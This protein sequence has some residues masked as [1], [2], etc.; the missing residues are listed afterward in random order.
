MKFCVVQAEDDICENA[1]S[2]LL[3]GRCM[4]CFVRAN[5]VSVNF[6]TYFTM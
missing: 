4:H 6:E 2:G 1:F 3:A 5:V